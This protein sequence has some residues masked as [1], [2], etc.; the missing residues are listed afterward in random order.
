MHPIILGRLAG[1]DKI[2]LSYHNIYMC[3]FYSFLS[4]AAFLNKSF[5]SCDEYILLH[6][7]TLPKIKKLWLCTRFS[8]FHILKILHSKLPAVLWHYFFFFPLSKQKYFNPLQRCFQIIYGFIYL[9]V[10]PLSAFL[11]CGLKNWSAVMALRGCCQ[12]WAGYS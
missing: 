2:I 12:Q 10:Y 3:C 6:S 8:F 9:F 11:L 5:D 7:D 1:I 4:C